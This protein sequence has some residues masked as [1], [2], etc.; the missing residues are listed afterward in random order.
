M[1]GVGASYGF[2]RISAIGKEIEDRV[3]A[4]LLTSVGGILDTYDDYLSNI[5]VEC[6]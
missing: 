1:K 5:R 6:A 2:A 3:K 4:G